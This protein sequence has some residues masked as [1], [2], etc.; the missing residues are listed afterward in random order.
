[1]WTPK[2]ATLKMMYKCTLKL[3][4]IITFPCSLI[5]VYKVA[6]LLDQENNLTAI[7]QPGRAGLMSLKPCR[8][9]QQTARQ[10]NERRKYRSQLAAKCKPQLE[11]S[12]HILL[13]FTL[14]CF[15]YYG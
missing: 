1:M 2:T 12:F 13:T 5:A 6:A 15:P 11:T 10:S 14:V 3:Q 9:S 8:S 4:K 7:K